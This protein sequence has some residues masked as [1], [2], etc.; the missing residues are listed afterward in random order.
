MSTENTKNTEKKKNT[1]LR[2]LLI[3]LILILGAG[4]GFAYYYFSERSHAEK[5]VEQFL[6][7][8]QKMDFSLM[9]KQLQSQDLSALD[10]VDLRNAVYIDF[11]QELNQQMSFEISDNKFNLSGQTAKVT[12]H[13]KYVDGSEIYQEAISEF[14]RQMVSSAF[15][16][17]SMTS[18]QAHEKLAS[19]MKEKAAGTKYKFAETD[20]TYPVIKAGNEWKIASL[21]DQTVKVMSANF[22]SVAKELEKS[23]SGNT[24]ENT[25]DAVPS[26]SDTDTIDMETDKFTIHYTQHRVGKDFAG[27]PCL[28]V[29]YDYTNNGSAASSAMVDVNIQAYQKG[30]VC[31]ASIPEANDTAVDNFMKEIEPGKT[32]N[33]CQVFSLSDESDVTLKAS[34]TFTFSNGKT[35]SQI[36]KIK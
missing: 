25:V 21:D 11:F 9:E 4:G 34:E 35:A 19:I 15:S 24:Q 5:S 18:D 12:A 3:L 31:D 27:K 23:L 36:L 29:Y 33:V 14:L 2:L 32:V 13:I 22:Q 17:E 6:S 7:G 8:V 30:K 28:L 1:K 10:A 20:I 26:P 16:E